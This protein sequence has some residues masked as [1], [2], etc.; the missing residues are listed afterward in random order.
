M[1]N[2][3][4]AIYYNA[5]FEGK[6][7]DILKHNIDGTLNLGTAGKL[8]VKG[9][10][11][12]AHAKPGCASLGPDLAPREPSKVVKPRD[13]SELEIQE[14]MKKNPKTMGDWHQA[15]SILQH[16][17]AQEQAARDRQL[18]NAAEFRS[19]VAA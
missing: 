18:P 11:V 3:S 1:S 2:E 4:V 8:V 19:T 13:P 17:F 6:I 14:E 12:S 7:F 9:C 10:G 15:R 5:N 16:R